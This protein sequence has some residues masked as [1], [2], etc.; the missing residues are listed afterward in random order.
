MPRERNRKRKLGAINEDEISTDVLAAD[1]A[2]ASSRGAR[3]DA[4]QVATLVYVASGD[5]KTKGQ[6]VAFD[7]LGDR[8]EAV[9]RIVRYLEIEM[10]QGGTVGRDETAGR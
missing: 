3:N 8:V 9:K 4:G 1:V 7:G 5:L 6:M 10:G 2:N